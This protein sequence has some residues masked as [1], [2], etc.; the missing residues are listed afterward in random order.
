MHDVVRVF[1]VDDHEVVRAGVEAL[2]DREPDL[3][4]VGSA[5][6]G[7]EALEHLDASRP[8]VVVLD[9]RMPGMSGAATCREIVGRRPETGVVILTTFLDDATVYSCL[10]AGARGFLLKG[11]GIHDLVATIRS[12]GRGAPVLQPKVLECVLDWF[13][14]GRA[15]YH[16]EEL[17]A[18][19]EHRVLS[20]VA[21]GMSN[22]EI[23]GVLGL[24]EAT[25]KLYLRGVMKKLGASQR[26][27]VI[28]V[29]IQRGVI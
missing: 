9:H 19:H 16:E 15:V 2:I 4:V 27:E 17:L 1:V 18:D 12:V 14:S 10:S 7:E 24:S 28:A 3:L 8:D 5:R 21:R 25:V 23:G 13:S 11:G 6:S 26:G 22:R 29:G 20:L